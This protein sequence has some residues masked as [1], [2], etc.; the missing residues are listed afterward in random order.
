V[1]I[2]PPILRGIEKVLDREQILIAWLQSHPSGVRAT[3]AFL[4]AE[5]GQRAACD[6]N[7]YFRA[8][9]EARYPGTTLA[10]DE[11]IVEGR[12]VICASSTTAF[13]DLAVHIVDRLGGYGLAVSTAKA[14]SMDKSAQNPYLLFIVPRDHGDSAASSGLDRRKPRPSHRGQGYGQ[15]RR[16]EPAKPRTALSRSDGSNAG[17]LASHRPAGNRQ[18]AP[19]KSATCRW[20]ASPSR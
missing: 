15:R 9:F 4:L 19:G 14:L 1:V 16:H 8:L 18:K 13:L 20:T 17:G 2:I 7:L 12:M 11:R 10:I 5:A 6:H 3:G